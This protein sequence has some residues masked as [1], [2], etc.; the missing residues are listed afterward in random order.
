MPVT[1]DPFTGD[2]ATV[3]F[4]YTF[5]LEGSFNA[6]KVGT[7]TVD[8]PN[9]TLAVEGAGAD[10]IHTPASKQITFQAGSIPAADVQGLITRSTSRERPIDFVDG[11]TLTPDIL[12]NDANRSATVDEEIE[13]RVV[14]VRRTAPLVADMP[15]VGT[16]T[17]LDMGIEAD[18]LILQGKIDGTHDAIYLLNLPAEGENVQTAG[19][20]I[21]NGATFGPEL[22]FER[23]SDPTQVDLTVVT[24]NALAAWTQIKMTAIKVPVTAN[25]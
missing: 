7:K 20:A 15:T 13:D 24:A 22:R 8:E 21:A 4:F 1:S 6:V 2:G 3:D 16:P 23:N 9:Y 25:L 11:S 10:Y 14:Q 5:D 18:V 12:D 19:L 17:T